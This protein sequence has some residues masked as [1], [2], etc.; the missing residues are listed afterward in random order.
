MH[1][2]LSVAQIGKRWQRDLCIRV[3]LGKQ[4]VRYEK[5]PSCT[6]V[7]KAREDDCQWKVEQKC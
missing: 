2:E 7:V 6:V 3:I 4:S 5:R 1:T